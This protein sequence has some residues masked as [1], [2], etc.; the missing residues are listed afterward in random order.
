MEPLAGMPY[1]L[2]ATPDDGGVNFALFSANATGVELCLFDAAGRESRRIPLTHRT[3]Q[4]WHGYLPGIGAGQL[5]GYRVHGPYLPHL[6]HRFNPNKLLLDPYAR[7]LVGNYVPSE[8]HYGYQLGH[9]ELDLSFD[10][11][12]NAAF[13]PKCRVLDVRHLRRRPNNSPRHPMAKS[14]IYELHPKGF[15]QLHPGVSPAARGRFAALASAEIVSYLQ[16][17]GVTCVELMPVQAFVTEPFLAEKQLS[18]YWGYNSIGFFAPHPSYLQGDDVSEFRDMVDTLHSAGIEVILDVVYNHSAEGNRLGPTLSFRGIDNVS[19][20]RL[21]PNIQRHYINDTG[22]GNTLNLSHPRV[23]QLVL[24]SLRYWVEVMGVDGF[25]FDLASCLGRE[26]YGFDAGAGFFDALL[27][28]PVLCQVKLIAEPWDIGPGGYQLGNFPLAFS[29]WN[30]RYRDTMRRFWRGD[31]GILPEFAR[32]FHGSGDLFEHNGR[33]PAASINFITSH[34]GFSLRDLVSYD[35]R[36]NLA[37]GEDNRDGHQENFSHN[38]GVEGP[39][40]D[41]AVV[42]L[43]QRQ[44][45]NLLTSLFLSQGVPMLLAG[46]EMGRSQQGNNNAYCQDNELNWCDWR[47]LDG[48]LLDFT[49]R[50]IALRRAFPLLCHS[51]FIHEPRASDSAGLKWYNRQGEEMTK[52]LWSEVH[53]RSLSLVLQGDLC[54]DGKQQAL[55]LM[56]NADDTELRF[57]PPRPAGLGA[58][59]CLLHTQHS[60]DTQIHAAWDGDYLLLDRSL[61]LFHTELTNPELSNPESTQS[62]PGANH[63]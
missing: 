16:R 62:Q 61:I 39:S 57:H 17:L 40:D 5:Y 60:D 25:R 47:H 56:V 30:D 45:R 58:W 49:R 41:G 34:D 55:L 2:G 28:D 20:Y 6:G 9:E 43:R 52:S 59:R 26:S 21:H 46:D 31:N 37:N 42:A 7:Q 1:P 27:Q 54:G 29:E 36:H 44:C 63:E 15:T 18:N 53:S 51:R 10:I 35:K 48:E 14:I 13:M 32:R 8:T 33:T 19:Y 12:D 23:L 11:R 3:Q 24:D 4:V 50:L 38:H 22:C